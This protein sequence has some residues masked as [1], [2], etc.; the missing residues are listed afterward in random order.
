MIDWCAR[1][2]K[3]SSIRAMDVSDSVTKTFTITGPSDF[4]ERLARHIA[5]IKWL[6]DIGHSCTA[7]ISVDGDGSDRIKV[8]EKLPSIKESG[9][10]THGTYPDQWENAEKMDL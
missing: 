2:K 4:V 6:G 10:K 9:V 5:F 1:Q 7:G 8:A 3:L